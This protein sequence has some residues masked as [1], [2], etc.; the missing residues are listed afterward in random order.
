MSHRTAATGRAGV[1]LAQASVLRVVAE[2]RRQPALGLGQGPALALGVVGDLVL[3][4]PADH[5][6]LRLRVARSTSR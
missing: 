2:V 5:E 3:A 1:R 4:E 6:V